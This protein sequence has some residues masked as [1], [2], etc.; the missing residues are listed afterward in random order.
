MAVN[1]EQLAKAAGMDQLSAKAYLQAEVFPKLELAL[2]NVSAQ[3]SLVA[4][5]D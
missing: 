3:S 5:N 1:L 4:R 2:N